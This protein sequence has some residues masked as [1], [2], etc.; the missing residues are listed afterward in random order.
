MPIVHIELFEGRSLEQKREMVQKVTDAIAETA[1]CPKAA[2]K[3][4]IR[5]MKKSH[6]SEGG[7]LRSDT[8]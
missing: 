2:V 1:N 8:E 3:I 5:E 4:V 7:V 6:F